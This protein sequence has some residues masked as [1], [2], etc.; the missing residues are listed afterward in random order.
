[1]WIVLKFGGTSVS[2]QDQWDNIRNIV[3]QRLEEGLRPLIVCSAAS[4]ISNQLETVLAQAV[5]GEQ[6]DDLQKI[7]LR[8]RQLAEAL[9]VDYEAEVSQEFSDLE[10]LLEGISLLREASPRVQAQVMA[11]GEL[12]LTRLARAYLQQ[13]GLSVGW[14]DARQCLQSVTDPVSNEATRYLA[15]RC[16]YDYDEKLAHEFEQASESVLITQ[17]FIASNTQGETVLLGRGGSDVSA[18]YFAAKIRAKRC[19]IWTDVPGIYTGNPQHIPEARHLRYLDYDEAQEIASTGGKV[20]HPNCVGPM[21]RAGIPLHVKF[22]QDPDREGT[23]ISQESDISGVQIKSILMKYGILLFSIETV[24]MWHQVGFLADVFQ[25][26]KKHGLSID[27]VSTSESSVTVSLDKHVSSK[28]AGHIDNLLADLNQFSRA[29]VIG[30][31]ASISLVGHNIRAILH[32]LGGI[33]EVFESQQIHLLSQAANDLNLTFVVDE[34]QVERIARRLHTVLI[35]QNPM[36]QYLSKSWQEEFGQYLK[37]PTPWWESQRDTLL[38]I[39]KENSPLYVYDQSS[40]DNAGKKLMDCDAVDG[41]FYAMKANGHPDILKRFYAMGL[42]FECVS[43][44]E[45]DTILK[46]FPDIDRH[47]ILF[48][49]N[50]AA[51]EEYEKALDLGL[52]LTVDSLYPLEHWPDIFSGKEILLR[53][54]PG[55]GEGHHKFVITGGD[56]SKFGIPIAYLEQARTLAEK[57]NISVIGLHVHSGSGILQPDNWRDSAELLISLLEQFPNVS[58]LN[59]GGGLGI[60]ERPGQRPLDVSAV[61]TSLK[62]IKASHPNVALW[63]EPG[64]FL[65]AESGIILAKVTQIKAKGESYFIGIETGMN[66]LIRPALYGAYHEIVNLTRLNA[67]KTTMANIVG[68]ICESGDTLGYSRMLPETQEGDI[69]LIANTGAYGR[70]MSS[71][72]NQ[73]DP[74]E[75]LYLG[76]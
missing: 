24:R 11:S 3:Q 36:S 25:C 35:D 51:R 43:P 63:L 16:L 37:R 65:V 28:E 13:V 66:S 50:F 39:A 6:G 12:M 46:L 47:R 48:T 58:I 4:Q 30:P 76:I 14:R 45:V 67:P 60:V 40:L 61:N 42:N 53:I 33:F 64:R 69:M 10:Q 5:S 70:V 23:I 27:L 21:K 55:H 71:H 17:G 56:A 7:A 18:A 38:A 32:K 59:L 68:P 74:A 44:N 26:F 52:Y 72:Y 9:H 73:R 2:S 75:E 57:N 62:A 41:V 34:D 31:C 1:M 22:T 19:E 20:L 15:A 54:D 49:P 29:K 8:Y